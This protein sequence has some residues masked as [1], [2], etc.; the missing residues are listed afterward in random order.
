MG[1]RLER[2]SIPDDLVPG[3]TDGYGNGQGI[4]RSVEVLSDLCDRIGVPR[5]DGFIV[6]FC[7]RLNE[8]VQ[9]SGWVELPSR[10][11]PVIGVDPPDADYYVTRLESDRK[12]RRYAVYSPK[13][14]AAETARVE[15]QRIEEQVIRNL[16]WY[17][18]AEGLRSVKGLIA[19]LERGVPF[20]WRLEDHERR[21]QALLDR[22]VEPR[23]VA[24]VE[25][26]PVD[27]ESTGG[28]WD[29]RTFELELAYAVS[30]GDRFHFGVSY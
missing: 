23:T 28:L 26:R 30:E 12:F 11:V 15:Y 25:P 22:G 8:S 7:E 14:P 4:L 27:R 29:L 19:L 20:A 16:P 1:V 17:D 5:L 2:G 9:A 21:R 13:G 3:D 18:P 10:E 24:W 6:D